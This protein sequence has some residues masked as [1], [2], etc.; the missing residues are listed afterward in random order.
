MDRLIAWNPARF[1]H[2]HHRHQPRSGRPGVGALLWDT[3]MQSNLDPMIGNYW[4]TLAVWTINCDDV[5]FESED[6]VRIFHSFCQI[7]RKV[8][9]YVVALFQYIQ[10][11]DCEWLWMITLSCLWRNW[12]NQLDTRI[13]WW[14]MFHC[15]PGLL[16]DCRA[17]QQSNKRPSF[18]CTMLHRKWLFLEPSPGGVFQYRISLCFNVVIRKG[19]LI[20]FMGFGLLF[21]NPRFC[22]L[23]PPKLFLSLSALA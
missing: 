22:S 6:F 16:T 8:I 17:T 4:F 19:G 12:E 15:H 14:D 11:W 10:K 1:R 2:H 21:S 3:W 23:G 18:S 7:T 9:I 5:P 13:F 20:W